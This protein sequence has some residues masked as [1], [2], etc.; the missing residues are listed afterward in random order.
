MEWDE[1]CEIAF[2]LLKRLCTE[3]PILA[4][5]D[6]TKPF[7]VHTDASEEGLGAILYQ[8]EDDGTDKVIAY[9]SHSLKKSEQKYHSSKLEFLALKWAITDQFHKYLYGGTFEVHSDNN[10]LTYVLTTAKLDATGQRWVAS[11]ANYNFIITYHSGKH[12]INAD[13]LS[14]VPWNITTTDQPLLIKSALIRGTQG[15]SSIPMIPPDL[16]VLSKFMQAQEKPQLTPDEWKQAQA[17]DPDIG[18]R[19][20]LLKAKQ[21]QE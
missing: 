18:P 21:L 13:A 19:V 16:R 15:G 20:E 12:N 17:D 1:D 9:A 11:V 6:Y 8:T 7:K 5:A 2:L 3:V 10:P 4:Y 14:R